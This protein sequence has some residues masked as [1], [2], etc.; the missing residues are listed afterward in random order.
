MATLC[1][2]AIFYGRVADQSH[3]NNHSKETFSAPPHHV[4]A[5]HTAVHTIVDQAHGY[6]CTSTQ[7]PMFAQG[8]LQ[9][10]HLL[11]TFARRLLEIYW[12]CVGY[13]S[14]ACSLGAQCTRNV[15][16]PLSPLPS[17][18]PLSPPCIPIVAFTIHP[19]IHR[20]FEIHPH[21]C[22]HCLL[23]LIHPLNSKT[24]SSGSG[25]SI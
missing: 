1:D 4:E 3:D 22:H 6:Q 11:R 9:A 18:S 10:C 21:Y 7:T 13:I 19:H 2:P 14:V 24:A 15:G 8:W 16:S 23:S 20:Y 12:L 17:L 25:M 5:Q